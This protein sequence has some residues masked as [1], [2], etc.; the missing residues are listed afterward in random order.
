MYGASQ[1]SGYCT[2]NVDEKGKY[3]VYFT[4]EFPEMK[5]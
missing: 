1:S 3:G 5:W 4:T 2:R